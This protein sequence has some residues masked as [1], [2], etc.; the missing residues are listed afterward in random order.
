[1]NAINSCWGS[2]VKFAKVIKLPVL[3]P[4]SKKNQKKNKN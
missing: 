2:Y 4:N 1:M 3:K